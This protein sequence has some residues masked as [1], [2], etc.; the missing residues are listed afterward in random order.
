MTTAIF[1][2]KI[3]DV[4][5]IDYYVDEIEKVNLRE[6]VLLAHQQVKLSLLGILFKFLIPLLILLVQKIDP[7]KIII[8]S[9]LDIDCYSIQLEFYFWHCATCLLG[10]LIKGVAA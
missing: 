8:H 3:I 6:N 5:R 1:N 10:Y 2:H 4:P 7:I 9:L